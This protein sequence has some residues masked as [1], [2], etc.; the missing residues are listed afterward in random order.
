MSSKF[1][2][3]KTL[4]VKDYSKKKKVK[5]KKISN[6]SPE[7]R[8]ITFKIEDES[9]KYYIKSAN[10]L[11]I[12]IKELNYSI[13]YY[14]D[15]EKEKLLVSNQDI[16]DFFHST[17]LCILYNFKYY[18]FFSEKIFEIQYNETLKDI[19]NMKNFF[20]NNKFFYK[21]H[22]K[23][24]T[25]LNFNGLNLNFTNLRDLVKDGICLNVLEIF[26]KSGVGI[27]TEIF[28]FFQQYRD[29]YNT[30][31][32]CIPF[33]IFNYRELKRVTTI[34]KYYLLLN[35][36]IIN[37]FVNFED[38]RQYS[39]KLFQ[40]IN[41]NGI[42]NVE[43]IIYEIIN[44][45][46]EKF[47]NFNY[48]PYIIIDRYSFECDPENIFRNSLYEK[49][50]K[51][52]FKLFIIYSYLEKE[53]NMVLYDYLTFQ[54]PINYYFCFTDTLYS[55]IEKLPT[56]YPDIYSNL[57]PK[58]THF[59]MIQN[60]NNHDEARKILENRKAIIVNVLNEF[61]KNEDIQNFYLNQALSI[62]DKI[63]DLT[64]PKNKE[65]FYNIP[66]ELFDFKEIEGEKKK[67]VLLLKEKICLEIIEEIANNSI[68][69]ILKLPILNSLNNYIKE[70]LV[71][72]GI[73]QLMKK[74]ISPFG[75]FDVTYEI[76]CFLNSLKNNKSYYF[77]SNA[78]RVKKIEKTKHF[79][80]LQKEYAEKKYNGKSSLIIPFNNNSKD[81]NIGFII[82]N[83]QKERD[84][85][86]GQISVNKSIKKIKEMFT[87]FPNKIK[88]IKTKI[89]TIYG[90]EIDYLNVL[91]ILSKQWQ[92]ANTLEFLKKYK[93]PFIL[94]DFQKD[95]LKFSDQNSDPLN[96]PD[97]LE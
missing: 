87:D 44:D 2:G 24:Y 80:R 46:T 90:I 59:L 50:K 91:F 76:D 68:L 96:I 1:L 27:T 14:I 6:D 17:K 57:Y 95:G 56:K 25:H 36:A 37:A 97:F 54:K 20:Y 62:S 3:L 65:L 30:I 89:K 9:H 48:Q 47:S 5:P 19:F 92:N 39:L 93:I 26:A 11:Q 70:G 60:S 86:L 28:Y 83:E 38:Y 33:L 78:K 71:E 13:P 74:N 31:G 53:T 32:R 72:K 16:N 77:N 75:N 79:K 81:W 51:N 84:L 94:F 12:K 22:L 63:M 42:D 69:S 41:M 88:F 4:R 21:Y 67:I 18:T 23:S 34:K 64:D 35:F 40:L 7:Q 58:I 52:K 8:F 49:V 85:C 73:I 15:D 10:D 82:E 43:N 66:F 45:M 29:K 55:E 61:Y